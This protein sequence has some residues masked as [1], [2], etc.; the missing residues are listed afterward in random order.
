MHRLM[1]VIP[2]V[3]ALQAGGLD[4]L[5][6]WVGANLPLWRDKLVSVIFVDASSFGK[7]AGVLGVF[8]VSSRLRAGRM[9]LNLVAYGDA[10]WCSRLC[11]SMES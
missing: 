3:R 5:L 1:L 9:E 2:E 7:S 11:W 4:L 6:A 10:N 8:G